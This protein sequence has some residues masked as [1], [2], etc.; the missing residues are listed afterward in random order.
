MEVLVRL[1]IDKF[2]KSGTTK[3]SSEGVKMGFE[4][5]FLPFFKQFD[6][7]LFRKERLWNEECDNT[8]KRFMK[9]I[10]ALY[11][12]YSGKY[13]L[14]GATKYMSLEEFTEMITN[15]GVITES[16][17]SREISPLFNL[18]MM[19]QKNELDFDRHYNMVLVEMIEAISRVADKLQNLTDYFPEMPCFNKYKLDKKI[20]SFLVI[21]M[22]NTLPKAQ[23]EIL[24]KAIKKLYEEELNDPIRKK[25]WDTMK[26]YEYP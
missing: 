11:T 16:F 22:R 19:T 14:P 23:A 8:L 1:S 13:A 20:E 26:H 25:H 18:S 17:G 6:C 12:K 24:E 4:N 21:L 3:F 10:N 7:H 9:L 2:V 5:H 15:A